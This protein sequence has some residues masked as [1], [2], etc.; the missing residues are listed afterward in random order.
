MEKIITIDKASSKAKY[1]Q[2]VVAII[3]PIELGKLKR[4]QQLPSI[5]EM[6]S[7]QQ[8]AKATVAKVMKLFV[9]GGL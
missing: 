2:V 7:E 3:S 5:A 8:L 9:K 1:E 4:W 6:A